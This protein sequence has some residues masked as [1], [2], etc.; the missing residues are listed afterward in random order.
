MQ[1]TLL[2]LLGPTGV[3]KTGLSIDIAQRF[4]TEIISC[5]SRQFYR[6]MSIG[7]AVP[8]ETQL[9]KTKHHFIKFLSVHDYYS[10][11]QFES[12][13]LKLLPVLFKNSNK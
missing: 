9:K 5:D 10:S 11:S 6:E 12:D 7:T 8:D 1:N 4:G 2:V 13:V 3:G